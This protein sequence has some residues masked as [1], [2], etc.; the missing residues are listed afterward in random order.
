M[1]GQTSE[2]RN[3]NQLPPFAETSATAFVANAFV[4]WWPSFLTT[5]ARWQAQLVAGR[6][7]QHAHDLGVELAG[8]G[9]RPVGTSLL[10]FH[11]AQHP[12][13]TCTSLLKPIAFSLLYLAKCLREI[14]HWTK[15]MLGVFSIIFGLMCF[16]YFKPSAVRSKKTELTHS[17]V[18]FVSS[19][20]HQRNT[21]FCNYM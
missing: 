19:L 14:I 12:F 6:L 4:A 7:L 17:P 21:S 1:K 20:L 18:L 9:W 10:Y 2:I 16:P 15:T 13:R 5:S 3:G 8:E 11:K